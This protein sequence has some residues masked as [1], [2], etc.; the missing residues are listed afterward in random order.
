MHDI[1]GFFFTGSGAL[2]GFL[3]YAGDAGLAMMAMVALL[4]AGCLAGMADPQ[5]PLRTAAA[6][7]SRKRR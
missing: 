4:L 1:A 5:A 6:R 3:L 7:Q 2:P